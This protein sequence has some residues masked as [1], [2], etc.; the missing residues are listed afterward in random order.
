MD[1]SGTPRP[2][3]AARPCF[4]TGSSVACIIKSLADKVVAPRP[5]RVSRANNG[6]NAVSKSTLAIVKREVRKEL[7][8]RSHLG[9]VVR[10]Q[11]FPK[12]QKPP[13]EQ[14]EQGPSLRSPG[15][16]IITKRFYQALGE[17]E[18][19]NS[20]TRRRFK[21]TRCSPTPEPR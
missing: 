19:H 17:K 11:A 3:D 21:S 13:E 7:L 14:Q 1:P 15:G 16:T 10:I 20:S 6:P 18:Y 5:Y 4:P 2:R 12:F 8:R 9:G